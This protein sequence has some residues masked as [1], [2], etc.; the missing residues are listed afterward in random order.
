[1]RV[2]RVMSFLVLC[3]SLV[4]ASAF[5]DEA[6]TAPGLVGVGDSDAQAIQECESYG[7]S[8]CSGLCQTSC[9]TDAWTPPPHCYVQVPG[10]HSA[11]GYCDCV[12]NNN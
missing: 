5:G 8:H 4:Q 6:C 3:L 9:T 12:T 2:F 7:Q 1:M 11:A 10:S